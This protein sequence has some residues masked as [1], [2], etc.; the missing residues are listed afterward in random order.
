MTKLRVC[1]N[2]KVV[3]G[4]LD[5]GADI[6]IISPDYWHPDWPLEEADIKFFGIGTL[7]QV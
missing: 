4:L 1:S 2:D 6:A 5:K 3:E 7:S